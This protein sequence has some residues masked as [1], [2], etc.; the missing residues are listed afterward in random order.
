MLTA[1]IT[2][3][4]L[5]L[6]RLSMMVVKSVVMTLVC[7]SIRAAIAVI[8]SMSKPAAFFVTGSMYSCGG[9]VVSLPIVKTPDCSRSLGRAMLVFFRGGE[10]SLVVVPLLPSQATSSSASITSVAMHRQPIEDRR[11]RVLRNGEIM[12]THLLRQQ[13]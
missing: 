13:R 9:Y 6:I 12:K 3:S 11:L 10:P 1:D 2:M 4:K 5:L 7:N 8:R